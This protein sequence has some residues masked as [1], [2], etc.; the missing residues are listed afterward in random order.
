MRRQ[1]ISKK[2]LSGEPLS[3]SICKFYMR[4]EGDKK[5]SEVWKR[6]IQEYTYHCD[7]NKMELRSPPM[8]GWEPSP[9]NCPL[10]KES[11]LW[12]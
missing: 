9:H 11:C 6:D 8:A 2:G 10:R 5:Y 3:C 7:I 4:K 1:N 12:E